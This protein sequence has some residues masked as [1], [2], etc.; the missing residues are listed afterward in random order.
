[1]E[2]IQLK[3][4]SIF[5]LG[6][7]DQNGN[8]KKDNNG[9]EICL[10][11]DLEDIEAPL[12]YSKAEYIA[13][14]AKQDL[15]FQFSV[16]EKKYKNQSNQNNILS[17]VN[18]EKVKATHHFYKKTEEAIDLFLGNEATKKIFGT[19]RYW[20]MWEDLDEMIKPFLPKMQTNFEN[21]T[22]K[23]KNKYKNQETD[24]LRDE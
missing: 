22:N 7:R 18:E 15:K 23:I 1:M 6:I 4:D 10:E 11:I 17:R 9:N 5:R 8:I 21:I 12:K 20:T 13:N 16:I 14:K 24:V 19:R 3:K 2:Y